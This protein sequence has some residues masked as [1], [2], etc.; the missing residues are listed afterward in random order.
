MT[1]FLSGALAGVLVGGFA[2]CISAALLI[3]WK[4]ERQFREKAKSFGMSGE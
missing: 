1:Q 3:G 2:G 4:S